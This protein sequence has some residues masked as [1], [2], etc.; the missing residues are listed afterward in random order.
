EPLRMVTNYVAMIERRLGPDIS[1][2]MR[3]YIG[4]A[5]DGAKR[6]NALIQSL[7]EYARVGQTETDV[8]Q[9]ALASAIA[10]CVHFLTPAITESHATVTVADDLPTVAGVRGDLVRLFQNLIG[11]A[12]KYRAAGR[13]PL[14][15]VSARR[16]SPEFWTVSVA[17]NGIGID[18]QYRERVF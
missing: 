4:F 3:D 9:V 11:N 14:I 8:E 18:P 16:T 7:L 1:D 10:E 6:M 15:A 2:D 17:D 12:L 5:I 13:D